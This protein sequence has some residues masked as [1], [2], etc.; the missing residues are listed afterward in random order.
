MSVYAQNIKIQPASEQKVTE[1]LY[2]DF[3]TPTTQNTD[4]LSYN[5]SVQT[6]IVEEESEG[7]N[8]EQS[9]KKWI[10]ISFGITSGSIILLLL[11]FN[12]LKK[13]FRFEY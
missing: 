12:R 13:I 10:W 1:V 2:E 11:L 3:G 6:I 9:S 7:L 8:D 4:S 5:E